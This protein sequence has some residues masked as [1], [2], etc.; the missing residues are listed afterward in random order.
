MQG[1]T[2]DPGKA[3]M[4]GEVRFAE[5]KKYLESRGW[6]LDRIRG[7]HHVF[8]KSDGTIYVVPV[9][10]GKVKPFYVREIKKIVEG[11]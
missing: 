2:N 10:G 5:I 11:T 3:L 1:G 8:K 7:S 4:P 6:W 9:H